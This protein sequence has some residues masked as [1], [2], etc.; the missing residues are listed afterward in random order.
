MS[1]AAI[2]GLCVGSASTVGICCFLLVILTA[3]RA[4]RQTVVQAP[5]TTGRPPLYEEIDA[6]YVQKNV[7][8]HTHDNEAYKI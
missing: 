3:W 5:G 7:I 6:D 1:I 8:L 4:K 2:I